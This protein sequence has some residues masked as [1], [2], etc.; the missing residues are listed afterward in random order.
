MKLNPPPAAANARLREQSFASHHAGE[1]DAG[2]AGESGPLFPEL[3]LSGD[4]PHS[5]AHSAMAT[6][7]MA[8][9][10]AAL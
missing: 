10:H 7:L 5:D 4:G 8:S 9:S 6:G 2:D 3:C 1:D